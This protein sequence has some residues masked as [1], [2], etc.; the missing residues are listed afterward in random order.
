M[1]FVTWQLSVVLQLCSSCMGHV[2]LGNWCRFHL[3]KPEYIHGRVKE[4]QKA[5]RSRILLCHVDVEDVVGPL[6]QVT[7]IAILNDVTLIC[8]WSPQVPASSPASQC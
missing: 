2:S 5:F 8:A 6:A 7:R 3:L 1:L 4:L